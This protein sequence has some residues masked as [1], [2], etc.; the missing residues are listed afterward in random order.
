MQIHIYSGR[1]EAEYQNS[2][3]AENALQHAKCI[4]IPV[5]LVQPQFLNGQASWQNS[6]QGL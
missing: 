4:L 5:Y 3:S 1:H 2:K 6:H